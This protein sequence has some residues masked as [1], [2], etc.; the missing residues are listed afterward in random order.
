M[1]WIGGSPGA[2]EVYGWAAWSPGRGIFAL[3]NPKDA[4]QTYPLDVGAALELPAGTPTRWRFV[5]PF[6]DQRV[7]NLEATAG[8]PV[9]IRLEPF[10]VLVFEGKPLPAED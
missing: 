7:K 3:R 10:E 5:G 9:E 1:H 2:L 8:E 4:A 6:E